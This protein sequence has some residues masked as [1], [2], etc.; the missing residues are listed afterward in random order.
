MLLQS[1]P[2]LAWHREEPGPPGSTLQ[3]HEQS[4]WPPSTGRGSKWGGGI[5]K[6]LGS[7]W[8]SLPSWLLHRTPSQGTSHMSRGA[9]SGLEGGRF[10][11]PAA[12]VPRELGPETSTPA[13]RG[14]TERHAQPLLLLLRMLGP[15]RPGVYSGTPWWTG[16]GRPPCAAEQTEQDPSR[17][18]GFSVKTG[19]DKADP[20]WFVPYG[21]GVG[22]GHCP[23][24]SLG[25]TWSHL[26]APFHVPILV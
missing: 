5:T 21:A 18:K 19:P 11:L 7:A 20:M 23:A 17:D 13:G 25:Q 15:A 12:W 9:F 1:W 26:G 14:P 22:P 24:A 3:T 16:W 2:L 8:P 4:Q 10:W 6:S